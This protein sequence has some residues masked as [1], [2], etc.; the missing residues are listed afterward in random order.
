[1]LLADWPTPGFGEELAESLRQRYA[2]P[3]ALPGITADEVV[4][5]VQEHARGSEPLSDPPMQDRP[6]DSAKAG[7]LPTASAS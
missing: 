7:Y 5:S 1:M 4:G 2:E 3:K 6:I